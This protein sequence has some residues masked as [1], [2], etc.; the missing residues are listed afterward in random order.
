MDTNKNFY[1]QILENY[2][3]FQRDRFYTYDDQIYTRD[4][5]K[6]LIHDAA[7]KSVEATLSE[8]LAI[9]GYLVQNTDQ[10]LTINERIRFSNNIKNML[11]ELHGFTFKVEPREVKLEK[12]IGKI[13]KTLK[14]QK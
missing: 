9:D 12:L 5:V 1:E 13:F 14:E 10:F 11:N 3:S 4:E 2:D 6:A 7:K 8:V